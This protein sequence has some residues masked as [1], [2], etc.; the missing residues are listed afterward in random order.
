MRR[1]L[2]LFLF[3]LL[4]PSLF[5]QQQK[6]FAT[7]IDVGDR[8]SSDNLA[9]V[10]FHIENISDQDATNVFL[11]LFLGNESAATAF[12]TSDAATECSSLNIGQPRV[13]C[14][15]PSL[16]AHASRDVTI[17]T[18]YPGAGHYGLRFFTSPFEIS[19]TATFYREYP[20][21][22]TADAGPGSF[23][24][25]I[26]DTNAQCPSN[27]PCRIDFEISEPVPAEGWFTIA[28][29][30]PLP[31]V[32]APEIAIDGE[33]QTTISGDSNPRGPEIFLDGRG[34][35]SADGLFIKGAKATVRGLA[36]GGFPA[37]GLLVVKSQMLVEHNDIGTD[38]TGTVAVP[39]GLRGIM[40]DGFEAEI[41]GNVLSHNKR[42]GIFLWHNANIHDN[43]IES[44]GASGIFLGGESAFDNSIVA[45]NVIANNHEFGVAAPR[46]NVV[47][48]RANAI[49]NNR[50]GGIDIGLD[51]RTLE[52]TDSFIGPVSAPH[53][54]SARFDAASGDTIIE[55]P[56]PF[57]FSPHKIDI[58]LYANTALD[59]DGFAEGQHF[60]GTP[61]LAN[62]RFTL[63]VHEDL[64][65]QF[66]DGNTVVTQSNELVSRA[67]S[68][69]GAPVRVD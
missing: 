16:A 4:A 34:V 61:Q 63:R 57:A 67:T 13:G 10:R 68:E 41:R 39:N 43:R 25:A 60:L 14:R 12:K 42:S 22:T 15:I 3:L 58:Y 48:V 47:E 23:R 54:D 9:D 55:G 35:T 46:H 33:R 36:I 24:Q 62:G 21:T 66:I 69:F 40:G 53:I 1:L 59:A 56:I 44:N 19:R 2:P 45:G 17:T 64:R 65:G 6:Q 50:L 52:V 49:S 8:L 51:G 28:P 37:N 5:S 29:A 11:D 20:V 38:P 26:L 32:L 31:I 7:S 30:S 18:R 27:I